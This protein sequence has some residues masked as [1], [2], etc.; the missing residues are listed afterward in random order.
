MA[1]WSSR[2]VLTAVE[3]GVFTQLAT[4]P[5]SA[6]ELIAK[7]RWQSRA[8]GPVL[9]ALVVLGLLRRIPAAARCSWTAP[10]PATRAG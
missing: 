4:G 3:F 7:L 8:A 9:D 6:E 10:S 5:L 2:V 1:F